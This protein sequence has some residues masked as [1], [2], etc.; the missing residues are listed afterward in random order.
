MT[1][2]EAKEI[3]ESQKAE[4]ELLHKALGDVYDALLFIPCECTDRPNAGI[5]WCCEAMRQITEVH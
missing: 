2:T 1:L 3:I 4:L 5:C